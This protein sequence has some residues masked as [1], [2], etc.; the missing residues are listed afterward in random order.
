MAN[1][2]CP[3]TSWNDWSD[4]VYRRTP[5][6]PPRTSPRVWYREDQL[7]QT[8]RTASRVARDRVHTVRQQ[9]HQAR[10]N[11]PGRVPTHGWR[12]AGRAGARE[13]R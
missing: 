10:Q 5:P 6:W 1:R 12:D 9:G 13:S 3:W 2:A 8:R 7:G 11:I 4:A